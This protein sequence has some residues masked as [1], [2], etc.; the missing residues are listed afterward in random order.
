M[1]P[2]ISKVGLCQASNLRPSKYC[3]VTTRT[4]TSQSLGLILKACDNLEHAKHGQYLQNPTAW[5]K[6]LK[7][8]ALPFERNKRL[9]DD[10]E[11]RTVDLL[12]VC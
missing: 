10:T 3:R 7:L 8:A 9:N 1:N 5:S 12:Q 2:S 11:A 6:Q 4:K